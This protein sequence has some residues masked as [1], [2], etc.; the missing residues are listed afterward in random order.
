[1][2]HIKILSTVRMQ[3]K[4]KKIKYDENIAIVDI[5]MSGMY[6]IYSPILE[7]QVD[8]YVFKNSHIYLCNK[9][10]KYKVVKKEVL[11]TQYAS[12]VTN[13]LIS[14]EKFNEILHFIPTARSNFREVSTYNIRELDESTYNIIKFY[15]DIPSHNE[16]LDSF[17]CTD[18]DNLLYELH[19]FGMVCSILQDISES[20]TSEYTISRIKSVKGDVTWRSEIFSKGYDLEF[21]NRI[22]LKT[23]Y[24]TVTLKEYKK[25]YN[26]CKKMLLSEIE[27][28]T[29][30]V[31][32]PANYTASVSVEKLIDYMGADWFAEH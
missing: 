27:L 29:L 1:M 20:Q 10:T 4:G 9:S 17:L 28:R 32:S 26:D 19:H 24:Q 16:H 12:N 3:L 5:G 6:V 13:E 23:D 18:P 22:N 25:I 7:L 21:F 8:G 30:P 15:I 14:S 11:S 31:L 2:E